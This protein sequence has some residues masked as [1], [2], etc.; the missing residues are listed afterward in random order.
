MVRKSNNF[1]GTNNPNDLPLYREIQEFIDG[2]DGSL[3]AFIDS[4][5]KSKESMEMNDFT[6][7]LKE[8]ESLSEFNK[9]LLGINDK[10]FRQTA[11]Y[12][13]F[14]TGAALVLVGLYLLIPSISVLAGGLLIAAGLIVAGL[15]LW[16]FGRAFIS[17]KNEDSIIECSA[18]SLNSK[19]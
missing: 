7:P 16:T 5:F 14:L 17:S 9:F 18:G 10:E 8:E 19:I 4:L 11:G 2:M 15:G 13:G 12:T 1:F 6:A 3:K